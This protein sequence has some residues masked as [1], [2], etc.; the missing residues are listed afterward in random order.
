MSVLVYTEVAKGR[1]KKSSL[2]CVNYASKIAQQMGSSVTAVINNADAA[3]IEELGKA[4]ANKV[5]TVNNDKIAADSTYITAMVEQASKAEGS[6]VIVFAFDVTGKACA[7]RLSAKLKAGLVAGAID[8]PVI[9]G[10]SFEVKKN[11]FSGKANATYTIHSDIKIIS[12]LPNSFPVQMGSTTAATAEFS[13]ELSTASRIVVKETKSISSGGMIPLP[14][15]ELVVSAGRGLKGPENWKIVED[16]ATS[17]GATTACSR[18]VADMHWRPH[19]EHVGQT[20]VAIR[21]NLYIAIGISGAI[22]HLAGVNG[23]KTIVVINNDKEAPFFKSADY[24]IVGDAF[25][26][27]PKLTEAV[28]KF[29]ANQN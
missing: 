16:L 29:K 4:G 13:V 18:P 7:P 24:G 26:I 23:S 21:P 28:K 9:N 3:Q 25:T 17:L 6:K 22:Q 15:A 8:Y 14:E 2:E 1:V 19:H 20:G 11:V 10:A 5:L 12:L 27:L